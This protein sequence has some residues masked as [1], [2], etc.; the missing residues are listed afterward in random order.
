MTG[1]A[2]VQPDVNAIFAPLGELPYDPEEDRV[3]CHLCGGWFRFLGGTHLTRAHGWTLDEYREEFRLPS[4]LATCGKGLSERRRTQ[5]RSRIA[6]GELPA[7]GAFSDP[8]ARERAAANRRLARWRTLQVRHPEL[9]SELH[10]TRNG[11]LDRASIAAGSDARLWWRC[12]RGHEWIARVADRSAGAGCPTCANE[13]RGEQ[14][15]RL[16]RAVPAP[17]SLAARRPDL[18]AQLHPTR[19][20][21]VDLATLGAGSGRKVWWRCADGHEWQ[22]SVANRSQGSRCP[23]CAARRRAAGRRGVAGRVPADRTLAVVHPQLVDELHPSRNGPLDL[24]VLGA[25]SARKLWWRCEAGHEWLARVNDRSRG[26]GCPRCARSRPVPFERSLACR[27]PELA[28]QLH[29][30]RNGGLDAAALAAGSNAKVW[31]RCQAGHEWRAPVAARV[32]GTGCP[33]CART[34]VPL[35]RSLGHRHPELSRE[36]HPLRNQEI[37]PF[38]LAAFS[39]RRVWWQCGNGHEWEAVVSSRAAGR[40]CP[41]CYANRRRG[42]PRG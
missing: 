23:V 3:Q 31:W 21:E 32:R 20:V 34:K 4:T 6:A 8:Q 35:E 11:G 7:T 13:R 18:Y 24:T 41:A 14:L 26:S 19:N 15:G 33:V 12:R 40:G 1:D 28:E 22:A 25:G 5:T 30:E 2:S 29:V 36:L 17:R 37:D 10:P 16:N 9:M 39:N 38:S 27:R 42:R